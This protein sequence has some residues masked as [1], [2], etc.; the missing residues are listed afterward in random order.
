M[1]YSEILKSLKN[2]SAFDLYRLRVAISQELETPRR[3]KETRQRLKPEQ[4]ISYFD[5]DK[6]KLIKAKVIKLK[7][8]R[9]SVEH[10]HDKERWNIPFYMVNLDNLNVDI[11]PTPKTGLEKN[12]LSTG[13]RVS[14][15]DK[16]NR[17]LYGKIIRLNR[18]TVT[19]KTDNNSQWRVGYKFLSLIID[20]EEDNSNVIEGEI[21]EIEA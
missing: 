19:I 21:L 12:Q 18:K 15:P 16:Q 8:T 10:L 9:V 17:M 14:F 11:A 5:Q 13:D 3:T 1:N 20:G 6:N 4:E 2:A 7:R